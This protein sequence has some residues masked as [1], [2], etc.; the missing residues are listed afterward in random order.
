[1][2]A[3]KKVVTD[4][5]PGDVF[6]HYSNVSEFNVDVVLDVKP[7]T[8]QDDE[9]TVLEVKKNLEYQVDTFNSSQLIEMTI[10]RLVR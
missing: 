1:M 9:I 3:M 6:V 5:S 10:R 8:E 2:D 7:M 4:F